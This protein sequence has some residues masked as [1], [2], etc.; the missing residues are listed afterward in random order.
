MKFNEFPYQRPDLQADLKQAEVLLNQLE[1]SEDAK[2]FLSIFNQLNQFRNRISTL[3][4]LANVRHTINTADTFYDDENDWW[5]EN[6][7]E[8]Q[9]IDSRLYKITLSKSFLEELKKQIPE[10][11][12]KTAEAM[13]KSFDEKI[14]PLLQKENKL[15]SSYSKLIA[16]AK[17]DLDGKIYTLSQIQPL[18][19]ND[20]REL[21]E[22]ASAVYYA[23]FHENESKLD[24][25]YD[26]LVQLRTQIAKELG[27]SDYIELGYL[28]MMRFD[29]DQSQVSIFRKQVL[30]TIV[31]I[32]T[33]LYERQ[34]KRLNLDK[35]DYFDEK[36]EFLSG[37]PKPQ[38]T[39]DE[40]L[41]AAQKM[42]H[43]MSE[44]TT[45]F[46]DVMIKD[47]LMDLLSKPNKEAGGYCTSFADYKVPF[48]FSNF[49]GTSGDVDVL[50][51]EAGHAFQAYSS[52]NIEVPECVWPTLE[53]C[54]IHSMSM[55]FFAWPWMEN[56]FGKDTQK[57][58][59]LHL[60]SA[61][62]FIPYGVLVDHFQHEVYGHP[63]MSKEERKATWRHLEKMY[64]PH[65][66]YEKS[67][68]LEKGTW[69]Y[70]QG[71]IFQN[72]FYYIDYTLAQLCALQ[73]WSK[74]QHK[75]P[76][77]WNDY[78][79]LCKLGGTKTFTKLV[80]SANL[81]SPF[82]NGTVAKVMEDVEA[83]LNQ[84]EDQKL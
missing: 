31:P 29:Y 19:L 79:A 63:N 67:P 48:I 2:T 45:E 40:L 71:H 15:V 49:N 81:D 9:R 35:M 54:E 53:S 72:P 55:E 39:S 7:P 80:S 65:K 24:S 78:V 64:L 52:R 3:M 73:F 33:K 20:D 18:M 74:N 51:H 34:A 22:K 69:W 76:D 4:S 46:I 43:E 12:F 10:P 17:L 11:F 68:F 75:D 16:Q 1:N 6:G 62:K 61:I 84:V 5:D 57:Y 47:E 8:Y 13:I 44:E 36:F 14:I 50:T 28:R 30:E 21:R 23:F 32:A 42:Y 37:N 59:F 27:F 26:E 66:N 56:F 41:R 58:Y 60:S 25:I 70:K 83:Y 77:C 82:E 38:G